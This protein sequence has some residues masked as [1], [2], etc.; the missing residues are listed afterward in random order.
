MKICS[1]CGECKPRSEYHKK[2]SSKD[3]LK[4]AC[5]ECRNAKNTLY[6]KNNPEKARSS[7][8]SYREKNTELV[9]QRLKDWMSANKDKANARSAAWYQENKEKTKAQAKEWYGK[10]IERAKNNA[11]KRYAENPE[12]YKIRAHNRRVKIIESG[13]K[14]SRGLTLKLFKLQ[15]GK[16]ACCKKP[17]GNDYHM[18]HIMPLALGGTNTDDNIQLLRARCNLQ[19][20][21]KDPID[22]M[23]ERGFLL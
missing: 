9:K 23:Q 18:D 13:E 22:F 14:L 20:H 10:N 1:Q 8:V 4:A 15:K 7:W 21:A 3:G 12:P 11:S 2:T 16:C 5:K 19:K 6:R 17:L